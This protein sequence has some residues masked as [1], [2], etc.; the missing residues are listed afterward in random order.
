LLNQ[1][2][3][4]INQPKLFFPEQDTHCPCQSQSQSLGVSSCQTLVND[5]EVGV[6][7]LRKRDDFCLA[8]IQIGRQV[9]T[10]RVLERNDTQPSCILYFDPPTPVEPPA[11]T[12]A[13][14][15]DGLTTWPYN[16]RSRSSLP[17]DASA[18][19]GVV[20]TTTD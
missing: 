14:T 16:W 9:G 6:S 1:R 5:D 11:S 17:I 13:R 2:C 19:I 12:S 15:A 8:P 4:G 18:M 7:L 20:L 3:N 10:P